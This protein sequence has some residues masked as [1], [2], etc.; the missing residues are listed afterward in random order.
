MEAKIMTKRQQNKNHGTG[1]HAG[2]KIMISEL[3]DIFCCHMHFCHGASGI[4]R[5]KKLSSIDVALLPIISIITL[6]GFKPLSFAVRVM[7]MIIETLRLPRSVMLPKNIFL[8]KTAF[9]ISCSTKLF[10]GEI[11][12][13]LKEYKQFIFMLSVSWCSNSGRERNFLNSLRIS[14]QTRRYSSHC[15]S[16]QR[17]RTI[18]N[19]YKHCNY[20]CYR[21]LWP[22]NGQKRLLWHLAR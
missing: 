20:L 2:I 5:H 8:N 19:P 7:V 10:V 13:Y 6:T 9:L 18:S 11:A 22:H 17:S 21:K 15:K 1:Y 14:L 16:D 4:T 12:G 3:L